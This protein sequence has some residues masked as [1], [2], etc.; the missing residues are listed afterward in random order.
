M[1]CKFCVFIINGRVRN[2]LSGEIL[3][4]VFVV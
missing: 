3:L 4:E 1:G 2:L